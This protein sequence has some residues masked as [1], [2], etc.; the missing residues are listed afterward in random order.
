MKAV[1][2]DFPYAADTT[3]VV[4]QLEKIWDEDFDGRIVCTG[5]EPHMIA[6][7]DSL[8]VCR[9]ILWQIAT[10]DHTKEGAWYRPVM[11]ASHRETYIQHKSGR[12][13]RRYTPYRF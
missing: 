8:D 10:D 9:R 4:V 7:S 2:F 3:Y 1:T 6:G 11:A 12:V 13:V 5:H